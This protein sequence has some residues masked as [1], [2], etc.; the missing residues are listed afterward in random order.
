MTMNSQ[1]TA[2]RENHLHR[3]RTDPTY[4]AQCVNML[5]TMRL[6]EGGDCYPFSVENLAEA[7]QQMDDDKVLVLSNRLIANRNLEL[8]YDLRIIV[9]NYWVEMSIHLSATEIENALNS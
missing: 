9:N 4:K 8:G 2:D 6:K 1:D 5:A 7:L 3:L